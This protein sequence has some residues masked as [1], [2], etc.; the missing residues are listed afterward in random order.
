[1]YAGVWLILISLRKVF[2]NGTITDYVSRT[3]T[4]CKY[5][6]PAD[7]LGVETVEMTDTVYVTAYVKHLGLIIEYQQVRYFDTPHPQSHES[8]PPLMATPLWSSN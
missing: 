7:I 2:N 6:M 8:V 3:K 4:L 5:Y 1:M